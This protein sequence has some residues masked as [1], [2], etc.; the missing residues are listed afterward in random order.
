MA[1]E[2]QDLEFLRHVFDETRV[3]RKP[4]TGIITG[5]HVLPYI[6]VGPEHDQPGHSVEVR[7]RIKVSPRLV[8][9]AG[10]D[11]PTY[12]ELFRETELMDHRLVQRGRRFSESCSHCHCVSPFNLR[13]KFLLA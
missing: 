8:I 10:N 2:W 12:G 3:V 1:D 9:A 4:M 5:Y 11:A 13:C 6:L 7:G